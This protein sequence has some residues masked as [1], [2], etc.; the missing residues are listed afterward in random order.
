[1]QHSVI[2]FGEE[3]QRAKAK[4]A[5]TQFNLQPNPLGTAMK[6]HNN[7]FTAGVGLVS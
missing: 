7:R 3:T 6:A 4:A 5:C 1:M 2:G